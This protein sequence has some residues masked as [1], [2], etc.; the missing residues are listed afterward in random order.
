MVYILQELFPNARI[1]RADMDATSKK[2]IWAQT[3]ADFHDG[4]IDI[5]VGTQSITKGFHFPRV[6][7]VGIIWADINLHF[8]HYAATEQTLQQLIQVAGRAGRQTAE[9]LVI[10][11]AMHDHPVFAHVHEQDYLNFY[12]QE[13]ETRKLVGYPPY[14]R[15]AELELKH[16]NEQVIEHESHQLAHALVTYKNIHHLDITI[17]GPAKPLVHMVA[18]TH[19]RTIYLKASSIYTIG[20]LLSCIKESSYK[21]LIFFTPQPT[22]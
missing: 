22:H 20:K 13:I 6:T 4:T 15:L 21:S 18:K 7:L 1:A 12:N 10:I 11:Q 3:I 17:L 19:R 5:L 14:L 9:S 16:R 8:P 2:K